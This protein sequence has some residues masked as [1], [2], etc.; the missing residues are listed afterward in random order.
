MD[1]I[2]I[3]TVER[4]ND[5][6]NS[7]MLCASDSMVKCIDAVNNYDNFPFVSEKIIFRVW[8]DEKEI[9]VSKI[10]GQRDDHWYGADHTGLVTY[11]EVM[12]KMVRK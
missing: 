3:F 10:N 7:I 2:M 12:N 8:E 11:E 1:K 9:S 4:Y 5:Y 6:E